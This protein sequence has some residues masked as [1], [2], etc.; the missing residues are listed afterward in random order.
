MDDDD[1]GSNGHV[2]VS[3]FRFMELLSVYPNFANVEGVSYADLSMDGSIR[4]G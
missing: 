2:E 3:Q 4:C 1:D